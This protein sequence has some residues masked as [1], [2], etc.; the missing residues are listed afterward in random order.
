MNPVNYRKY[1]ENPVFRD[2][3]TIFLQVVD[4]GS[5]TTLNFGISTIRKHISL[6][7]GPFHKGIKIYLL[8]APRPPLSTNSDMV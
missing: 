1:A 2:D 4:S 6:A 8:R 3:Q 5:F 7:M